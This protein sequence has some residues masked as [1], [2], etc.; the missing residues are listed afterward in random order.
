[1]SNRRTF[2]I[3]LASAAGVASA[4]AAARAQ[5]PP[6]VVLT[7]VSYDPDARALSRAQRRLR[8]GVAGQ[9]RPEGHHPHLARR[10]GQ[11][12]ALGDRRAARPTSSPWR[13]PATSTRS[14]RESKLPAG[15]LA[16]APAQQ[17]LALHLDDRVPGAQGQSQG[18]QGLGRPR[19]ARRL[20]HHAQSR[21]PRAARA[22]TISPP[23]PTRST[24]PGGDRGAARR[25]SSSAIYKQRAG[26]RHRRARLDHHLRPARASAT[27]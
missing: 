27:C 20:G 23:G 18:D 16:D 2:L 6:E 3:A 14:P 13:W 19:Q 12:G 10:L 22:G 5:T 11:A 9:H 7:N 17:L 21:R 25:T 26:A 24:R 15:E 8:Q 1:M 4:T